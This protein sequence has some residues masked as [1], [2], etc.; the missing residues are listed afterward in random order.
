[1]IKFSDFFTVP[2]VCSI[3]IVISN[4]CQY[5][6]SGK[7]VVVVDGVVR[8]KNPL[9]KVQLPIFLVGGRTPSLSRI[10]SKTEEP[11]K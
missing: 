11:H 3:G 7:M 6:Y 9:K 8:L 2:C 1:M 4:Q 10:L 5:Y